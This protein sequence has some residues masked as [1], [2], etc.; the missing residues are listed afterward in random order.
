MLF[1]GCVGGNILQRAWS[2]GQYRRMHGG[3]G[4]ETDRYIGSPSQS[5]E[6]L[7]FCQ[8]L[9]TKIEKKK[10]CLT[11]HILT[12]VYKERMKEDLLPMFFGEVI[13]YKCNAAVKTTMLVSVKT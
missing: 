12:V 4:R 8:T 2:V 10:L 5:T 3:E 13:C 7:L 6:S 11:L 9:Q 1:K